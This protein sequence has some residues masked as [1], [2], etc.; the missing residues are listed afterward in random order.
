M[1]GA[2]GGGPGDRADLT[3]AVASLLEGKSK[4]TFLDD[5]LKVPAGSDT[6]PADLAPVLAWHVV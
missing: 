2:H 4:E 3:R 6:W 5:A 1:K